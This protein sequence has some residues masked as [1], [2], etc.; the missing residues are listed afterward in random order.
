MLE[1][2]EEGSSVS[3]I[4]SRGQRKFFFLDLSIIREYYSK[5]MIDDI[6]F[7]V[8]KYSNVKSITGR[9]V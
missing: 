2:I 6:F 3:T 8:K 9:T 1:T 4:L 7:F 5:V